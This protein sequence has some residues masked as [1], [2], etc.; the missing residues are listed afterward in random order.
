MSV[1]GLLNCEKIKN[2][3][4]LCKLLRENNIGQVGCNII[5]N[6]LQKKHK[7]YI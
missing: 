1:I 3:N 4:S 6:D 5:I 7:I 2:Y